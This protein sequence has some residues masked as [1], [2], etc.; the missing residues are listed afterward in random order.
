MLS[1]RLTALTLIILMLS[2]LTSLASGSRKLNPPEAVPKSEQPRE[3]EPS[4]DQV[5]SACDKA[6]DSQRKL[7]HS[8]Q[9]LIKAQDELILT[10][11]EKIDQQSSIVRSPWLWFAVG[12][13]TG[14]V[15][16]K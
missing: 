15:I 3:S 12:V 13:I 7:N 5:L 9:R 11:R 2:P 4:C 1:K 16:I 10:Q 14:V 6:L 8:Q